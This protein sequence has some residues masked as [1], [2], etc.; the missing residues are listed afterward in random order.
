ME[1]QNNIDKFKIP[2]PENLNLPEMTASKAESEN[3]PDY[4]EEELYKQG[5]I[6]LA[7]LAHGKNKK[8]MSVINLETIKFVVTGDQAE[9]FDPQ[10]FDVGEHMKN[11][12]KMVADELIKNK[13]EYLH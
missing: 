8:I 13:N 7:E 4:V 3:F 11:R 10:K 6:A 12:A 2:E 5:E 1:M 9:N